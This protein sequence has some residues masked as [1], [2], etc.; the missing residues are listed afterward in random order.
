MSAK[1]QAE[2]ISIGTE[3]LMGEIIDTNAKYLAAELRLIGIEV[4]RAT[5]AGDDKQQLTNLFRE[6]L[7]RTNLVLASGG[8]GPTDDDLTRDCVADVFGET[9]FV[10]AGLEQELRNYFIRFGRR[11]MPSHNIRQAMLIPSARP[12]SNPNG[13]APGWW[14]EKNDKTI[15]L[16]PGPPREME[17]MWRNEIRPR[18]VARNPGK[19]ALTRTL[20]TFGMAE[21][22][23]NE[24]VAP[25]FHLENPSLGIY[26]KPDGIHLRLI[27]RGNQA[28]DLIN[29]VEKQI[30][31]ILKE[32]IWGADEETLP[33]TIAGLLLQEGLTLAAFDS[34]TGGVLSSLISGI[35]N[36]SRFY[37]GSII[38]GNGEVK[39][40]MGIS[41]DLLAKYGA[42]SAEAAE[43]A[44]IIARSSFN[45]NIGLGITGIAGIDGAAGETTGTAFIGLA[46]D[47]GT[48]NWRQIII[49]R[50]DLARNQLAV[51]VLFHL[52]E[53]LVRAPSAST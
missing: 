21:A 18:L 30:R 15:I 39:T 51:A 16:I 3:L 48:T 13:T 9:L 2:L 11:Q 45:T 4:G 8:L 26:A 46:D 47:T 10:D 34:G 28:A 35:E 19:L 24:L 53:R 37:H 43:G 31:N 17:P 14:V 20:K 33:D 29:T 44:A 25:F 42:I 52:R 27:S 23:V 1:N 32:H 7:L 22:T 50:R 38:T 49:P 36:F 12:I 40:G 6:A 5:T 41:A